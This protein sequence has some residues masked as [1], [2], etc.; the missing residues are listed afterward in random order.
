MNKNTYVILVLCIGLSVCMGLLTGCQKVKTTSVT[1]AAGVTKP[2]WASKLITPGASTVIVGADTNYPPFESAPKSGD[3]F[4]GFDVDLMKAIGKKTGLSFEFKTY[5]FDSLVAGLNGGTDFDMVTSAWTI[6]AERKKQVN[7]SI[8]YYRNDFGVVVSKDSKLTS[9]KQLKK[10]DIVCVQTG[11]SANEWAKKQ[12]AGTG[13][14]IKTFENTLD[15][16]NALTAGD[17][18]AVI[19]D[20]AMATS[21][22]SD[23]ARD[24]KIVEH[25]SV[26]EYFGM[27]LAKNAKGE[28]MK[29][30]MDSTL[31]ELT[32]DGTYAKI[33]KKWFGVEPTFKPGD[34]VE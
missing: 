5:N 24:A 20:L 16:F 21:V 34:P 17:A 19:Q 26:A 10:G 28:A 15:C 4:V 18:G 25:V 23:S 27:G 7:F 3:N 33:Y 11:S 9:Y 12:F 14:Q 29:A 31:K 32:A 1:P 2:A 6:N 8:P 30:T 22:V 13:V